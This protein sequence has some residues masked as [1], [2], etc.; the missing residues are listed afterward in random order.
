MKY[1]AGFIGA[2]NMGGALIA[3]AVKV[4]NKDEIAIADKNTEAAKRYDCVVCDNKEVAR[5]S[6]F[7]FLGVKPQI[8]P[9]V[10]EEISASL[11]DRNDEFVLVTMA[12]G[13]SIK[14]VSEVY[15]VIRIMPNMPAKIGK[16]MILYSVNDKVSGKA[17]EDFLALM[18]EAGE[19]EK[20]DEQFIDAGSAVSGC[21]P[22]FAYMFIDAL[23]AGG[24]SCGLEKE[25]ALKFA[26]QTVLGAAEMVKAGGKTPSEM[27]DDVCSP[28]GTTIEGVKSLQSDNLEKIVI[29]A[30]KA[31][32]KRTLELKK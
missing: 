19:F 2:G 1:S 17:E 16:G 15:P 30:V 9:L 32:F 27:R 8:L 4:C 18:K 12:A 7:I 20:L 6:R 23:C 29:D 28:G 13:I 22:A 3:A 14:A 25:Q 31:S 24:E 10:L 26:A 21:G 5:L 11:S